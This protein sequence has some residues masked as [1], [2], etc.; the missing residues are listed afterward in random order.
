MHISRSKRE[1]KPLPA[2]QRGRSNESDSVKLAREVRL[3]GVSRSAHDRLPTQK[4]TLRLAANVSGSLQV[5]PVQSGYV[6]GN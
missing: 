5:G 4:A 1:R 6:A 3:A 2:W